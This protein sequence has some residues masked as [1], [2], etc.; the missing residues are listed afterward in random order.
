MNNSSL[1]LIQKYGSTGDIIYKDILNS[2]NSL[3][4]W[5]EKES[6]GNYIHNEYIGND[7]DF[8]K[9]VNIS[10]ELKENC[11]NYYE[12]MLELNDNHTLWEITKEISPEEYFIKVN[13]KLH[14][15]ESITGIEVFI[16]GRSGRH[17]CIEDTLENAYRL[18]ELKILQEKLE[19]ELIEEINR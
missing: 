2:D 14:E 6:H 12:D 10:Y 19:H 4:Y 17:I 18:N 9:I 15:F 13:E 1:R 5:L 8:E 11:L 3:E 16:E 7:N